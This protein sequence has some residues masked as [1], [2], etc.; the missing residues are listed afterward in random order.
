M[1]YTFLS[2]EY[3]VVLRKEMHETTSTLDASIEHAN[4]RVRGG[5]REGEGREKGGRRE[6]EEREKREGREKGRRR[7]GE[8]RRGKG[9]GR[10]KGGS[11]EGS[12]FFFRYSSR[13]TIH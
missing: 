10:E 7:E 2:P 1:A 3:S 13:R 5:R 6:G 8:R 4:I 12:E 9:E 11:R